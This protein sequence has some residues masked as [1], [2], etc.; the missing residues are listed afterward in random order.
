MGKGKDQGFVAR[1]LLSD[2]V[3]GEGGSGA[4]FVGCLQGHFMG[5]RGSGESPADHP[6]GGVEAGARWVSRCRVTGGGIERAD[7]GKFAGGETP[8]TSGG[9]ESS[10][11]VRELVAQPAT[12]E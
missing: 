10:R 2:E 6:E 11:A 3:E 12:M 8:S 1:G 5:T 4:V 9:R 7:V